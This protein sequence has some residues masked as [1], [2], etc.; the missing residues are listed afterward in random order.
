VENSRDIIES[1]WVGSKEGKFIGG[2]VKIWVFDCMVLT[3]DEDARSLN[4][5]PL[6][7]QTKI[8]KDR[9]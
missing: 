5:C 1:Y 6:Y 3:A 4:L 2:S 7:V 9:F 8:G